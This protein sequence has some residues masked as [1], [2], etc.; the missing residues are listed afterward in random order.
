MQLQQNLKS[1]YYSF[2]LYQSEDNVP[3]WEEE[4]VVCVCVTNTVT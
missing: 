2:L 3:P 4:Q 1:G